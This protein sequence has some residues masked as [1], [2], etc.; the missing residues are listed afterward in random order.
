[1]TSSLAVEAPPPARRGRS[2]RLRSLGLV[3]LGIALGVAL[4]V[5]ARWPRTEVVYR[6]DQPATVAYDDGSPHVL[7]L[8]RRS[9][10][11]GES[12]Q[13]VVGRDPGLSYG[14][15]VDIETS[16]RSVTAAEWTTAGVRVSFDTG[17]EL[18][19]PAR[20]FTGGR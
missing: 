16:A 1:M 19:I 13:I 7:A 4:T 5:A 10:L 20:Y 17:H 9:S 12:H 2:A 6:G 3:V 8:V 18:F 11:A 15:R 14:H